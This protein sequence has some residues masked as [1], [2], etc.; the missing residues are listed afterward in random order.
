VIEATDDP[1]QLAS[2]SRGGGWIDLEAV[3][4]S[5]QSGYQSRVRTKE[6]IAVCRAPAVSD[7]TLG[8]MVRPIV[9]HV[10]ALTERAQIL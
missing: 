8:Q 7:P 1:H 2:T 5:T 6:E 4:A 3:R 9:Q 10:A